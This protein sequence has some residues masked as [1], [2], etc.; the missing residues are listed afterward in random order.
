MACY[1]TGVSK[2]IESVNK[3]LLSANC[4]SEV[5]KH[6][7]NEALVALE[8]MKGFLLAK[9]DLVLRLVIRLS[10][11]RLASTGAGAFN[12]CAPY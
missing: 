12:I 8:S 2:S 7:L 5:L 6:E 4:T 10:A 1:I 9:S 11:T 3:L